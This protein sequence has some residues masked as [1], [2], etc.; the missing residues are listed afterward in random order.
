MEEEPA[1]EL[2]LRYLSSFLLSLPLIKS[3][4]RVRRIRRCEGKNSGEISPPDEFFSDGPKLG[5]NVAQLCVWGGGKKNVELTR[6][7]W[8]LRLSGLTAAPLPLA[9]VW[10]PAATTAGAGKPRVVQTVRRCELKQAALLAALA[11]A[12]AAKTPCE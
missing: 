8:C 6:W 3:P 12:L 2:Q 10:T 1:R 4:A 11:A 9:D 7:S 5:V